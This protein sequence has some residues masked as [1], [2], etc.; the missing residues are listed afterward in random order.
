MQY[1][2]RL[3][4]SIANN[5]KS[6][7]WIAQEILWSDFLKRLGNPTITNETFEQFIRLKKSQQDDLKDVGGFVGGVLK[8]NRRKAENILSRCLITLD[9]DNIEPGQTKKILGLVS[10]LS[11]GYAVYSTRK[12][13]PQKPRLRIIIPLDRDISAEE[14]EPIARKIASFIG[15]EIMDS[16]TFEASRLMYWP[17]HSKDSEFVFTYE[18][19]PFASAD[20]LLALYKNWKD[21]SEWPK[22]VNEAEVIKKEAAKQKDPFEKD[23]IVGAF[24]K[25]YDIPAVIERFL[26]DAYEPGDKADKY[27]YKQGSVA[28]GATVYGDGRWLYSFHA[29][30]PASRTL[31]NSFDLVRIHKFGELDEDAKEGTPTGRLP[32]YTEMCKFAMQDTLVRAEYEK[33]QLEK[34]R[35]EFAEVATAEKPEFQETNTEWRMKLTRSVNTRNN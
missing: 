10:G 5:R 29:T 19:K 8:D 15:M 34:A 11:C 20:G 30:D 12:H 32:S 2:K 16:S 23:N 18:D 14:Y 25:V 35:A 17:S 27:T 31:C 26:S 1:E 33:V 4:I 7:N 6:T 28:N 24:C 3:K 13:C 9:A 22:I 21:T